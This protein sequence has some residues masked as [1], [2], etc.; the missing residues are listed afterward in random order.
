MAIKSNRQKEAERRE[1]V[2][3]L[4]GN[5]TVDTSKLLLI[6]ARQSTNAQ[7]KGNVYS[8]ALQTVGLIQK[9]KELGWTQPYNE[10]DSTIAGR[11]ILFVENEIAEEAGKKRLIS[12]RLPIDVRLGLS[13]VTDIVDSKRA[14]AVMVV[15]ISRLFRDET[16]IQPAVFAEKCRQ[17]RV[18][19]ISDDHI[20]DFTMSKRGDVKKFRDEADEAASFIPKHIIGKMLKARKEKAD[21][22]KLGNGVAP[23]GLMRNTVTDEAGRDKPGDYLVPSPHA[24]KVNELYQRFYDKE[25]NLNGLLREIISQAKQG[26]P[27][28]P[29]VPGINPKTIYLTTVKVDGKLVGWTIASRFG[30]QTI[31]SN[32]QYAGHLVFRGEIVKRNAHK[33]IVDPFLWNYAY[34]HIAKVDLD[35]NEIVRDERTARYRIQPG[36]QHYSPTPSTALLAGTRHDGKPVIDGVNGAHVYVQLPGNVYVIKQWDGSSVTGFQTSIGVNELDC[37]IEKRLDYSLGKDEAVARQG[38]E[39]GR[40]TGLMQKAVY[41]LDSEA[42][43]GETPVS[44]YDVILDELAR[45]QRALQHQDVMTDERLR[46][47]LKKERDLMERKAEIEYETANKERIE[48]ELKQAK[49]D[50]KNARMLYWNWSL[51]RKRRFIHLVTDSITLEE[52]ADGWLRLTIRW[53]AILGGE[54]DC[55]YIWRHNGSFWTTEEIALLQANYPTASR[56]ELLH[57]LP[58]RS[59]LAITRKAIMLK[60]RRSAQADSRSS[61][62]KDVSLTDLQVIEGYGLRPEARVQWVRMEYVSDTSNHKWYHH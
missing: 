28:F 21:S 1:E 8:A 20:Y 4:L 47:T 18:Q 31:L 26:I 46:Q 61:L 5:V 40:Y 27:L 39:R 51:E 24:E 9:A 25:A 33:A 17:A 53:S 42:A 60:I 62:P 43:G 14:S 41:E 16:G 59:W 11:Y 15:D 54:T 34:S 44:E 38:I 52:I 12:G 19:V 22:G 49:E 32:P 58:K 23:V 10:E 56:V 45:V 50:V 29:L 13:A 3:N 35:G 2:R 37:I 30:L 57:L 55:C 7:F 48:A 36:K 6:Y